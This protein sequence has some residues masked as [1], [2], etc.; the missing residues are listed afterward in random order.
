MNQYSQFGMTGIMT[1]QPVGQ[2]VPGVVTTQVAMGLPPNMTCAMSPVP[3]NVQ[4]PFCQAVTT[5]TT[6]KEVGMRAKLV[7]CSLVFAAC[8]CL[9]PLFWDNLKDVVHYCGS[10]QR[11]IG[12]CM[13]GAGSTGRMRR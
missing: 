2:S 4:C 7:A 12:R 9:I 10:C 1:Q 3:V 6:E 13:R 5:T 8:C 11:E